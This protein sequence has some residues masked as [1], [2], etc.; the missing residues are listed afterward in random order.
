[1]KLRKC[2]ITGEMIFCVFAE[3]SKVGI[4]ATRKCPLS[5]IWAI[6]WTAINYIFRRNSRTQRVDHKKYF[7]FF[8]RRMED[9][10]K[11]SRVGSSSAAADLSKYFSFLLLMIC[12]WLMASLQRPRLFLRMALQKLF[13]W[14]FCPIIT[15]GSIFK[16]L[17]IFLKRKKRI[18]VPRTR[19]STK[20]K[21]QNCY[22]RFF[23]FPSLASSARKTSLRPNG[24]AT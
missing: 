10:W 5:N 8:F 17:F 12:F 21:K 15:C 19:L 22:F 11:R 13:T 24:S 9:G 20:K 4:H 16:H 14:T 1:M 6:N 7:S 2:L 3:I 23:F 18:I